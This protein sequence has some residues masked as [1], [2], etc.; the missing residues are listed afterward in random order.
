MAFFHKGRRGGGKGGASEKSIKTIKKTEREREREREMR[1]LEEF[2]SKYF[3]RK[4]KMNGNTK[5]GVKQKKKTKE[6]K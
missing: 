5:R 2:R 3:E 1:S 4:K 6:R